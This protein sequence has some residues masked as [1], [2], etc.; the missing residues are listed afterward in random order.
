MLAFA[1]CSFL[2]FCFFLFICHFIQAKVETEGINVFWQKKNSFWQKKHFFWQ[3]NFYHSKWQ[4]KHFF[5]Q[6]NHF[7]WQTTNFIVILRNKSI[8]KLR[9]TI[10]KN[11]V[12]LQSCNATTST[13]AS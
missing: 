8:E 6:K 9:N 11:V 4:K 10:N 12:S 5:W 2:A 7:N 13:C 3:T 1:F